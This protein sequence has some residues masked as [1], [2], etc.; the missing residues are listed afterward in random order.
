MI[1]FLRGWLGLGAPCLV[2]PPLLECQNKWTCLLKTDVW[3]FLGWGYLPVHHSSTVGV[4]LQ[5]LGTS[6]FGGYLQSP[7]TSLFRGI[8]R[9]QVLHCLGGIHWN[10]QVTWASPAERPGYWGLRFWRPK[11]F[12]VCFQAAAHLIDPS[13]KIQW[14][15]DGPSLLL[16]LH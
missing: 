12:Y 8:S 1:F 10:I 7:G 3:S 15:M 16:V 11:S 14:N 6:L 9:L 2:R 13:G 4:Y 5:T